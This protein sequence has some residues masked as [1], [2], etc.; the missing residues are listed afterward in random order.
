MVLHGFRA[1]DYGQANQPAVLPSLADGTERLLAER[2][3]RLYVC[4]SPGIGAQALEQFYHAFYGSP[5]FDI[6][7]DLGACFARLVQSP[8]SSDQ[9]AALVVQGSELTA[10]ATPAMSLFHLRDGS[11][12]DLFGPTSHERLTPSGHDEATSQVEPLIVGRARLSLGD[13][14]V[15]LPRRSAERLRPSRLQRIIRHG[16]TPAAIARRLGRGRGGP[17]PVIVLH[18]AGFSP[19]PDIGPL[20]RSSPDR[21]TRAALRPRKGTSPI[22][23]AAIIALATLAVLFFAKR[24]E[25]S[26]QDI[27]GLGAWLLTPIATTPPRKSPTLLLEPTVETPAEAPLTQMSVIPTRPVS[28]ARTAPPAPAQEQVTP[29]ALR[30]D[31][32]V[33]RLLSPQMDEV[34]HG[35]TCTLRWAWDG[36]LLADEHFDIRLWKMGT[37]QSSIAWTKEHEY[38]E[39]LARD[40][41]L[42]WTIVIVRGHDGIIEQELASTAPVNFHWSP[43]SEGSATARPSPITAVPTPIPPTRVNPEPGP[44]R[45]TPDIAEQVD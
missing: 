26:S 16:G 32:A 22:G 43:Q 40:G 30:A 28:Q 25:L 11:I 42:S 27:A 39:H 6:L 45:A 19:S 15:A 21:P 2:K 1:L 37:E 18:M 35:K 8:E 41:W 38:V 10:V 4:C 7:P 3:G 20:S 44:T 29:T 36:E 23:Y 17:I 24:P 34:L 5:S 14:V 33:A 13:T 12:R 9:M 31:Y